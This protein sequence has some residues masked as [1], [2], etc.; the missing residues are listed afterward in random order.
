MNSETGTSE[1]SEEDKA[2][3]QEAHKKSGTGSSLGFYSVLTGDIDYSDDTEVYNPEQK[4]KV[5]K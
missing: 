1:L 5:K 2:K 3:V 4:K